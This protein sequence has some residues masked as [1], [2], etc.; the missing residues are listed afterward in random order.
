MLLLHC[1]EPGR[2]IRSAYVGDHCVVKP[3]LFQASK[4]A[5]LI[6]A[7]LLPDNQCDTTA[8]ACRAAGGMSQA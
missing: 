3:A 5:D 8:V 7:W 1:W 2:L 6:T 4:T